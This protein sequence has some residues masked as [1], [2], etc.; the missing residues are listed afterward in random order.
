MIILQGLH[1]RNEQA[2]LA[3]GP[4]WECF[5]HLVCPFDE[6]LAFESRR[7]ILH[8]QVPVVARGED[9]LIAVDLIE[10]LEDSVM[11][12][13]HR[14]RVSLRLQQAPQQRQDLE[15]EQVLHVVDLIKLQCHVEEGKRVFVALHDEG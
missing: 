10:L 8:E 15:L 1:L 2:H 13:C 5:L 4:I 14:S 6:V 12:A 11:N 3:F 9:F 7:F